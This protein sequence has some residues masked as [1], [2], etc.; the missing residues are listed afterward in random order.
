MKKKL[1]QYC[2]RYGEKVYGECS[3]M[4][5]DNECGSIIINNGSIT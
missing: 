4:Y 1:I 3:E 2:L 5:V